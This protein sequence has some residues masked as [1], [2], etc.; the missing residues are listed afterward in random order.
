MQ[1]LECHRGKTVFCINYVIVSMEHVTCIGV[2]ESV[3]KVLTQ[4][5]QWKCPV[6]YLDI[7]WK[8]EL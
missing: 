6:E 1:D 3:C 4:N 5:S 7:D 2:K 8:V